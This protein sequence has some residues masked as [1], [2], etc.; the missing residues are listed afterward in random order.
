[1]LIQLA[2]PGRAS[3]V[4]AKCSSP[5]VCS[6]PLIVQADKPHPIDLGHSSTAGAVSLV[7]ANMQ[8]A[9]CAQFAADC[10]RPWALQCFTKR[11]HANAQLRFAALKQ[12]TA[13]CVSLGNSFS[14]TCFSQITEC[15]AP[16]GN[17]S[18]HQFASISMF[19]AARHLA[20]MHFLA[21]LAVSTLAQGDYFAAARF[22]VRSWGAARR[23]GWLE[24]LTHVEYGCPNDS[25]KNQT[26]KSDR[27]FT[28][29]HSEAPAP[30]ACARCS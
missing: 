7:S 8:F 2:S 14:V 6:L 13:E 15:S 27:F 9:V 3:L 22:A 28:S 1:M 10:I 24:E 12:F 21:K 30:Q 4:S 11:N 25:V 20:T 16:L 17:S 23:A 19:R 5:L 26:F 18:P 29:C